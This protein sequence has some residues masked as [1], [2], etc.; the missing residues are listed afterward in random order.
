LN[1]DSLRNHYRAAVEVSDL[2]R[3]VTP[4]MMRHTFNDKLRR[5]G[6]PEELRMKF[7]GHHSSEVNQNYTNITADKCKSELNSLDKIW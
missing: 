7:V 5:E 1:G 6:V 3:N 4:H 2:D